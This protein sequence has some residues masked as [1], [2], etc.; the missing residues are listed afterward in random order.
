MFKLNEAH[1]TCLPP[2]LRLVC[3]IVTVFSCD[4]VF[5][6]KVFCCDAHWDFDVQVSQTRPQGVLQLSS[7]H[8]ERVYLWVISFWSFISRYL[9]DIVSWTLGSSVWGIWKKRKLTS[10]QPWDRIQTLF[11]IV[12]CEQHTGPGSC[13]LSLHTGPPLTPWGKFPAKT[14]ENTF[15]SNMEHRVELIWEKLYF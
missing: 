9:Y 2:L 7:R 15:V 12:C 13:S 5:L 8:E 3:I 4:L 10:S 6:C 11:Q 1:L 14:Q